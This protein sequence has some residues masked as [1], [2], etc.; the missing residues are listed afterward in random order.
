MEHPLVYLLVE[1]VLV[2]VLHQKSIY[3]NIE[4]TCYYSFIQEKYLFIRLIF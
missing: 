3:H 4:L 1:F 2:I